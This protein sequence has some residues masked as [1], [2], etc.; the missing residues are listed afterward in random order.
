MTENLQCESHD[1]PKR[2]NCDR[3]ETNDHPTNQAWSKFHPESPWLCFITRND[4]KKVEK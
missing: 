2:F 4:S 3:H 1:C